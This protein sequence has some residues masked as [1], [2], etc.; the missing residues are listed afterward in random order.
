VQQ[1]TGLSG[2]MMSLLA[3]LEKRRWAYNV[4]GKYA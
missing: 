2:N 3:P 4:I 1:I